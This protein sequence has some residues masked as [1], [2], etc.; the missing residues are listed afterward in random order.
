MTESETK[1]A[2]LLENIKIWA[3]GTDNVRALVQTGSL[4]RNDGLAD[5][6]SDL[7]IEILA[8]RPHLLAESDTWIHTAGQP[9]TVLHLDAEGEQEWPARLVIFDNGIK[10]DFTLS[11][12]SRVTD[13]ISARKLNPLYERGYRILLD[14]DKLAQH[15]PVPDFSFPVHALPSEKRFCERVGEFWFEAF[16]IPVYLARNELFLV[17]QRDW[18]MKELLLEMIEWHAIAHNEQATDIW[19]LGKGIR[20]WAGEEIW[21]R[22]YE[23]FGHF[24]A[25]DAQRA[26]DATT[27]LYGQLARELAQ[28]KG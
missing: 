14:K 1:R 28:M 2:T 3:E 11:G 10:A 25:T 27:Q 24:D 15:L 20:S 21:A 6:F 26:Y 8:Y 23:T 13:M 16:H 9:V 12:L 19:H 17:K 22:L 7:D 4:V 18:T 5:E